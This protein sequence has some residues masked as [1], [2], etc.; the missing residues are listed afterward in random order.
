MI[1]VSSYILWPMMIGLFVVANK[2]ILILLGEKWIST[3]PYLQIF[4]LVYAL[5]PLQ[6]TNLSVMKAMGRK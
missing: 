4:C 6:T 1:R 2:I 3:V 5:Q